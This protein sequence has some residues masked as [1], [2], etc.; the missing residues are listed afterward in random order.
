[1]CS[2]P[3]PSISPLEY[4]DILHNKFF[5][6]VRVDFNT[7]VLQQFFRDFVPPSK[8][9]CSEE[10]FTNLPKVAHF[11]VGWRVS[12]DPYRKLRTP[13]FTYHPSITA[14]SPL[15]TLTPIHYLLPPPD[16]TLLETSVFTNTLNV[17]QIYLALP[18]NAHWQW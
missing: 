13:L 2:L 10:F 16:A 18:K 17:V 1:M 9:T 7:I 11:I 5:S 4:A 6:P 12:R 3:R 15:K 14:C 8:N